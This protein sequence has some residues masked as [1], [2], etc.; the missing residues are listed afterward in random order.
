[1]S[2]R[3]FL[4]FDGGGQD[5]A[6]SAITM[7]GGFQTSGRKSREHNLAVPMNLTQSLLNS[8]KILSSTQVAFESGP[9]FL[10]L[11]NASWEAIIKT[12]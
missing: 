4:D 9:K 6:F 7:Q 12:F 2:H 5:R 8:L 3:L 1:M 11:S 10:K